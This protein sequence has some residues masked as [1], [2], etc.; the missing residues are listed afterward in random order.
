MISPA[1]LLRGPLAGRE[2]RSPRVGHLHPPEV[3]HLHPPLTALNQVFLRNTRGDSFL[4]FPTFLA[5]AYLP[6]G[7]GPCMEAKSP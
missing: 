7:R 2:L 4:P 3:G 6:G 5:L 1:V